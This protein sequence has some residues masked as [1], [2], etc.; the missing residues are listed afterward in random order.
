MSFLLK[1]YH[2][3][4][5]FGIIGFIIGSTIT[6]FVNN[7]IWVYYQTW[8]SVVPMWLEIL[9]G[10]ILFVIGLVSTYLLIRYYR[11]HKEPKEELTEDTIQ[12]TEE[13]SEETE[14]EKVAE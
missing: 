4:T 11:K 9:L 6:L 2:N 7:K 10:G 8:S 3:G 12:K 14:E 1:K 13:N 5:F